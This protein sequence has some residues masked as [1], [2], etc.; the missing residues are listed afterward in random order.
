MYKSNYSPS[1][2]SRPLTSFYLRSIPMFL[3][4]ILIMTK[5]PFRWLL[6]NFPKGIE[7]VTLFPKIKWVTVITYTVS[8]LF[9]CFV[10]FCG[11]HGCASSQARNRVLANSSHNRGSLPAAPPR[12]HLCLLSRSLSVSGVCDLLLK[13]WNSVLHPLWSEHREFPMSYPHPHPSELGKMF[14][15]TRALCAP[16]GGQFEQIEKIPIWW[17]F[18]CYISVPCC[19][20]DA[21]LA[22]TPV[23]AWWKRL[24]TLDL[25]SRWAFQGA[26]S[27]GKVSVRAINTT[28]FKDFVWSKECELSVLLILLF[29]LTACLKW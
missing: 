5:H 9:V 3:S 27:N 18:R 16:V 12:A 28:N 19:I 7:I 6:H 11:A 29:I 13:G 17:Y 22:G 23:S 4:R 20:P 15:P 25:H 26:G 24:I 10:L 8:V 1:W 2:V 21:L 14:L